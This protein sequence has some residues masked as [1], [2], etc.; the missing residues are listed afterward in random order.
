[1]LFRVVWTRFLHEPPQKRHTNSHRASLSPF[2]SFILWLDG[3]RTAELVA[4]AYF[5]PF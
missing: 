1:V 5:T 3:T 4:D 2:V